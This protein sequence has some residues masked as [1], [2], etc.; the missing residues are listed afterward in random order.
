MDRNH[1]EFQ[2]VDCSFRNVGL[3]ARNRSVSSHQEKLETFVIGCAR[4]TFLLLLNKQKNI[5]LKVLIVYESI[6]MG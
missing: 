4:E 2:V 6:K 5:L 1:F 3:H